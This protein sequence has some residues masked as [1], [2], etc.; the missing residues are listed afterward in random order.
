MVDKVDRPDPVKK[1]E[2]L[3]TKETH[4]EG[5]QKQGERR[6]DDEYSVPGTETSWNKF[7]VGSPRRQSLSLQRHRIRQA[8]FRQAL[9]QSRAAIL[10]T[11]LIMTDGQTFQR[12]QILSNNLDDY[13]KWKGWVPG[14]VLPLDLLVQGAVLEV[15]IQIPGSSASPGGEST[16]STRAKTPLPPVRRHFPWQDHATGEVNWL[17]VTKVGAGGLVALWIIGRLARWW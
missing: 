7:R 2:I 5:Q 14:Q 1:Y 9:L 4:D 16:A 12:A 6:D 11:D 8:I 13:W 17:W 3:S 10:E 15:S